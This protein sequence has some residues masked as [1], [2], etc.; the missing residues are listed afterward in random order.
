MKNYRLSQITS[1]SGMSRSLCGSTDESDPDVLWMSKT[2][3]M[4]IWTLFSPLTIL[5]RKYYLDILLIQLC[6]NLNFRAQAR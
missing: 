5:S 2:L 4:C 3:E 1:I 6:E